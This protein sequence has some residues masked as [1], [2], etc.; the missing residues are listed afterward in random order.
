MCELHLFDGILD[1]YITYLGLNFR[2]LFSNGKG[3]RILTANFGK[4]R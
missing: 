2:Q 4:L 1:V 3:L